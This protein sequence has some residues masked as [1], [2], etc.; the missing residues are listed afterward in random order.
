M[1]SFTWIMVYWIWVKIALC[2]FRCSSLL[3]WMTSLNYRICC[4]THIPN[5]SK[6]SIS[7][8]VLR[9]S[10]GAAWEH[11]PP[12]SGGNSNRAVN[13]QG[14]EFPKCVLQ[15]HWK[16]WKREVGLQ[17][18]HNYGLKYHGL[19]MWHIGEKGRVGLQRRCT[20]WKDCIETTQVN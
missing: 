16:Y 4:G 14:L 18:P 17:A 12:V 15:S 1:E 10:T 20:C 9:E 11:K 6:S 8:A 7:N 19:G 13:S 3:S 2:G 5:E